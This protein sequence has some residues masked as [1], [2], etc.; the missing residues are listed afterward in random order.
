[1]CLN[2]LAS[3]TGM[4]WNAEENLEMEGMEDNGD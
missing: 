3:G 1:M 2:V 4:D